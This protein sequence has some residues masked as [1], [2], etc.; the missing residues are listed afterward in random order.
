MK[1]GID[2]AWIRHKHRIDTCEDYF[3]SEFDG[4]RCL[5]SEPTQAPAL[6]G[7]GR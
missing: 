4:A 1:L 2:V 5:C 6:S 3:A 7:T